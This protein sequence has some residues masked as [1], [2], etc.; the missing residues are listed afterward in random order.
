MT[1]REFRGD[2][3]DHGQKAADFDPIAEGARYR[4]AAD[5]S[6]EIWARV[7]GETTDPQLM[8]RR[9]H[10]AAARTAARGGRLRP[11]PGRMTLADAETRGYWR[12]DV[13]AAAAPGKR[14]LVEI[15]IP[16][17]AAAVH[18]KNGDAVDEAT[19]S[20]VLPHRDEMKAL[21]AR[22]G[23]SDRAREQG[24]VEHPLREPEQAGGDALLPSLA[25]LESELGEGGALS[26]G[27]VALARSVGADS[28]AVRVHRG[29]AATQTASRYGALAFAVGHHVVMGSSAPASDTAEGDNVL[30][31]ELVHVAQQQDAA[32]DPVQRTRPISDEA[33]AAEQDAGHVTAAVVLPLAIPMVAAHRAMRTGLQLQRWPFPQE[34][35]K[36]IGARSLGEKAAFIKKSMA[37][38]HTGWSRVV[39]DVF[40]RTTPAERISLQH[41]LDMEQ[42]VAAMPDFEATR[43]GTLG[44]LI[45]GQARLNKKRAAYIVQALDDF[46]ERAE[47]FI[48][49]AFRGVYDD[50]AYAIFEELANRRRLHDVLALS[51]VAAQV[52]ARGLKT[53]GFNEPAPGASGKLGDL[54]GALGTGL[55]QIVKDDRPGKYGWQKDQL[56]PE[57]AELLTK[58]DMDEVIDSLTFTNML[59]GAIDQVT[60]GVPHGVVD[61]GRNTARAITDLVNGDY[62]AAGTH[63][64]PAAVVLLT[65]LGVKAWK[66][67][68]AV[69]PRPSTAAGTKPVDSGPGLHGPEGPGQFVIPNFDGPITAEEARIGAI[70]NLNPEAQ[71]AMGRLLTRVGQA[72]V[73]RAAALVQANSRAALFVAEHGER[74]IYALLEAD[75]DVAMAET[76]LPRRQL[77][78]KTAPTSQAEGVS[79]R[80]ASKE[81]VGQDHHAPPGG[82]LMREPITTPGGET[83]EVIAQGRAIVPTGKVEVYLRAGVKPFTSEMKAEMRRLQELK[84]TARKEFDRSPQ[85]QKRIDELRKLQHNFERSQDMA[86]TLDAAG[87]IGTEESNAAMFKHLLEVGQ[88]VTSENRLDV[89]SEVVGPTFKVKL[90]T[91]W[92]ILPDGRAYLATIKVIPRR[93]S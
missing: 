74:G 50:D 72:G 49:F 16:P 4:L 58:L 7:S 67:V 43:L 86:R 55:Q 5:T 48:L 52:K 32:R 38:A 17:Q 2:R 3:F 80:D 88:K 89:A 79:P 51:Q 33:S 59:V 25:M 24:D 27:E 83:V 57:Y 14:T 10:E 34:T 18:A 68:R 39:V 78:S 63:L 1:T 45:A 15:E 37:D 12:D 23:V 41:Q 29:S 81:S 54:F 85:N 35:P 13:F 65:H 69:K 19:S 30:L 42:L 11:D 71:A 60:F 56:P 66:V 62:R 64:A 92:I 90:L 77:A 84:Q 36:D 40:E 47:I 31:H 8:R 22:L 93:G 46:G 87:L 28:A 6:V 9:F 44:P 73:T 91:T 20:S 76:K 26:A 53:D 82:G 75:G 21:L 70:F 61:L